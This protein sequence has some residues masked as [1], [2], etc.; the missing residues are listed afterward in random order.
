MEEEKNNKHIYLMIKC[1]K[2]LKMLSN[3]MQ[4]I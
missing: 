4:Q 1:K 2:H 3:K